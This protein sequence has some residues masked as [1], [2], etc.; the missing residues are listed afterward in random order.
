MPQ[1]CRRWLRH[2]IGWL[3]RQPA[4]SYR[5]G[6]RPERITVVRRVHL[7]YEGT[8]SA[9]IVAASTLSEMQA[10]FDAEYLKRYSFLMEQRGLVIEAASVEAIGQGEAVMENAA[11]QARAR[12][13]CVKRYRTTVQR[14]R[15]ARQRHCMRGPTCGLA[16]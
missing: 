8:D 1:Q 12:L 11:P 13:R 2:S 9:L 3:L 16:T 6:S 14:G 7:R 4:I 5:K 10:A 15:M